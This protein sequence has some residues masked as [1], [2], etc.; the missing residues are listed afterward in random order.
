[1]LLRS[2]EMNAEPPSRR[3][4]RACEEIASIK[5]WTCNSSFQQDQAGFESLY[6]WNYEI[7]RREG[8]AIASSRGPTRTN[9]N[10]A[11]AHAV[12]ARDWGPASWIRRREAEEIDF[13]SGRS[14]HASKANDH[15]VRERS[16]AAHAESFLRDAAAIAASSGWWQQFREA[17][18]QAI[19]VLLYGSA[20]VSVRS[21]EAAI[22]SLKGMGVYFSGANDQAVIVSCRCVKSSRRRADADIAASRG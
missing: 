8:A 13:N 9:S 2:C 12:W 6:G 10:V 20:S 3:R 4:V 16:W 21:A 11:N 18:A 15:A 22:A 17:I 1:M 5:G 7:V 14:S 19:C